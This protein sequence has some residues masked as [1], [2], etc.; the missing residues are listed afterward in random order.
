[1]FVA[2]INKEDLALLKELIEA[3]KLT[4][5]IDRR[6]TLSEVPEAIRYSERGHARGKVVIT[7]E[8]EGNDNEHHHRRVTS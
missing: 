5:V 1:M 2:S 3:K 8:D 4:P 7:L 6:Y